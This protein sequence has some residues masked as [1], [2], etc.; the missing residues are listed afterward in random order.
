MFDL[1]DGTECSHFPVGRH[2]TERVELAREGQRDGVID[3]VVT[4]DPASMSSR[5]VTMKAVNHGDEIAGVLHGVRIGCGF[6]LNRV[7]PIG[8]GGS[9]RHDLLLGVG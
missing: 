2:A 6:L 3:D 5:Q 1:V 9:I 8:D 4:T 7:S